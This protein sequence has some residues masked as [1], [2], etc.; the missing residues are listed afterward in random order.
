LTSEISASTCSI[1]SAIRLS[2]SAALAPGNGMMTL[3]IV[4]SICGS[5]SRGVTITANRPSNIPASASSGVSWL[6]RKNWATRPENPS[7]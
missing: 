7:R 5:S 6:V 3:A 4:T 1:G 2:T